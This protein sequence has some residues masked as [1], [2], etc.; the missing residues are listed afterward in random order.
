MRSCNVQFYNPNSRSRIS[1]LSTVQWCR[2]SWTFLCSVT[3]A[4]VRCSGT[5]DHQSWKLHW[6]LR[7]I[8]NTA[9]NHLVQCHVYAA[10]INR[11]IRSQKPNSVE[12]LRWSLIA[13]ILVMKGL[14]WRA[15]LLQQVTWTLLARQ[16]HY[17]TSFVPSLI[18]VIWKLFANNS[19]LCSW[20]FSCSANSLTTFTVQYGVYKLIT[21]PNW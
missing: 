4:C 10:E 2:L 15:Y 17:L 18:V 13:R 3:L 20:S 21:Q 9:A 14:L 6:A 12:F 19:Q 16:N 11:Y 5:R 7:V 1:T 8:N